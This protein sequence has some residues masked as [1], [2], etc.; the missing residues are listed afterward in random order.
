MCH[1]IFARRK[2]DLIQ[3]TTDIEKKLDRLEEEAYRK[4]QSS[5]DHQK[6]CSARNKVTTML[7]R[8]KSIFFASLPSSSQKQFWKA[9][10]LINKTD[11]SIPTLQD[12]PNLIDVNADKADVL[13]TF[14]VASIRHYLP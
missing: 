9:V 2:Y 12:G 11:C 7:R 14:T 6:F 3:H 8:R 5:T 10:K 1:F 13:N 4:S